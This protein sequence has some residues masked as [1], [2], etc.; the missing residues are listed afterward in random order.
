MKVQ[1]PGVATPPTNLS[2][3][4]LEAVF[5]PGA[6]MV[7]ASLRHRGDELLGQRAGLAGY[8]AEQRTFGIPLLYPWANRLGARRF[9]VAGREVDIDPQ[10]TPL[11]FDETGLPIHGLLS[12]VSG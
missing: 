9:P 8:V 11:R 3:G 10:A 7:C 2:S 6:G 5:V 4:D 12:G 1:D